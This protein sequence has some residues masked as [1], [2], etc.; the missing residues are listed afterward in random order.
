MNYSDPDLKDRLAAEYVLGTLHGGARRRFQALIMRDPWLRQRVHAWEQH[1]TPLATGLPEQKPPT[2]VWRRIRRGIQPAPAARRWLGPLAAAG[3][4]VAAVVL[5]VV[6]VLQ[7]PT[8]AQWDY[9]AVLGD[10]PSQPRWTVQVD[11]REGRVQISAVDPA[12][13]E[14]GRTFELWILPVEEGEPPRS[15]GLLPDTGQRRV[16]FPEEIELPRGLEQGLAVSTEP[17]GGSPTGLPTG[18]I[19]YLAKPVRL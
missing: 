14:Q 4:A 5:A 6:L 9:V 18:E 2:R 16:A 7:Q 17:E 13:P 11:A 19:V 10:D 12:T 1:L 3:G 8:D 15:L